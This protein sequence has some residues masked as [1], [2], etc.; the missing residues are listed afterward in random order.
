MTA[1]RQ[2]AVVA[3]EQSAYDDIGR[4]RSTV[5]LDGTSASRSARYWTA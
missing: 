5:Y 4:L 3:S 2:R 1:P